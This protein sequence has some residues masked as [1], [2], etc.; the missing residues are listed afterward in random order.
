MEGLDKERI[1]AVIE[2]ASR[3]SKFYAKQQEDQTHLHAQA[4]AHSQ[5]TILYDMIARGSRSSKFYAK[6]QEDGPDQPPCP[7]PRPF[8][9]SSSYSYFQK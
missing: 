9:S 4:P 8:S 5:E 2:E 3:G 6:Q 7:G 1:N